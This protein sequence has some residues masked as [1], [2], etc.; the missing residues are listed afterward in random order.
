MIIAAVGDTPYQIM[1]LLHVLTALVAFAPAFVHPILANQAKSL[2]P[3]AHQGVLGHMVKNG[4]RIYAP[5]L[6]VTGI[7]GFGLQGM[8]EGAWEFSQAWIIA[9]ILVWIAMNGILHAVVIPSERKVANG[10]SSAEAMVARGGALL[11]ILLLV[12]L[13]LMVFKPGV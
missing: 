7:L 5:A 3:E 8:S 1:L 6:I 4:R 13:Y 10:D 11:T 9:A 2:G 12:M